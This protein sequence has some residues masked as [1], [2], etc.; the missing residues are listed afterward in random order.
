MG[1]PSWVGV[2]DIA[3]YWR[4]TSRGSERNDDRD[5]GRGGVDMAVAKGWKIE[6][7]MGLR[8]VVIAVAMV[9]CLVDGKVIFRVL[10]TYERIRKA[11]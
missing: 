10:R 9:T 7:V 3:I 8:M 2:Y 5:C 4:R 11:I 6:V 1:V